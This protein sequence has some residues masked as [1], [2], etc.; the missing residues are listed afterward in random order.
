MSSV[1]DK[2]PVHRMKKNTRLIFTLSIRFFMFIQNVSGELSNGTNTEYI[3]ME[4]KRK[5]L[6]KLRDPAAYTLEDLMLSLTI[7]LLTFGMM[8]IWYGFA[9]SIIYLVYHRADK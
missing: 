8:V 9:Q 1:W 7:L 3:E 2:V 6:Y 5:H 4:E